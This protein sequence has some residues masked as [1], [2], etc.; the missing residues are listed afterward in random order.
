MII[1]PKPFPDEL[2]GSVIA[3]GCLQ[4]GWSTKYF[5]KNVKAGTSQKISFLMSWNA[6]ELAPMMG[7]DAMELL[8]AHTM[9]P[10]S[11]AFMPPQEQARL[12]AKALSITAGVDCLAA[13][14]KNVSHGLPYRRVCRECISSELEHYGET[15]WHREHHLPG[16]L[17]CTTHR[18]RL[19]TTAIVLRG[20]PHLI[21]LA[22]PSDVENSEINLS[23]DDDDTIGEIATISVKALRK[24][25]TPSDLWLATYR[26]LAISKGYCMP[27]GDIA[28]RRFAADLC[29]Q[30]GASFLAE[31]G[32]PYKCTSPWPAL[33]VREK[34]NV[35][36]A[37]VKHVVLQTFLKLGQS[38]DGKFGYMKH[39]PK[40]ADCAQMDLL[41]L[42][43]AQDF[44]AETP[45][46]MRLTVKEILKAIGIW[47]NRRHSNS[48][49]PLLNEW[50]RDFKAS[51]RS[52][53]QT[54]G[55]SCGQAR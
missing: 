50:L 10:Y 18:T 16:V 5:T 7:V 14:T 41:A 32:C 9:L 21:S 54:G 15:Y 46:P 4:L 38:S 22:M 8:N 33:M 19:R 29:S 24:E 37:T 27:S 45:T 17:I 28:G 31:I 1:L 20:H 39:G 55:R 2:I 35:P 30:F 26:K 36:F 48:D 43:R 42:R 23:M 51:N 12:Y 34:T 49:F 47:Q 25:I 52:A 44:I 53:R 3:R 13:L 6:S 11:I 40:R